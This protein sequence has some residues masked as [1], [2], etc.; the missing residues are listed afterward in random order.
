MAP[1]AIAV[2]DNVP[3]STFIL[4]AP[5]NDIAPAKVLAPEIFLSAPSLLTPFPLIDIGS[6]AN[7][8]PPCNCKAAPV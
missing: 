6:A 8:I 2:V 5:V 1:K 3:A 7:A 4:A